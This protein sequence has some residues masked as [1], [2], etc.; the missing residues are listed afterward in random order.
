MKRNQTILALLLACT[1]CHTANKMTTSV[2]QVNETTVPFNTDSLIPG[3]PAYGATTVHYNRD[4]KQVMTVQLMEPQTL[5]VADKPEKWGHFQ[6]P[7]IDKMV[8]GNV[9]VRWSLSDDAMEAYGKHKYGQMKS[10]D[11][12]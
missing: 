9:R 6:F 3:I 8:D 5:S 1:A 2:K 11:G 10:P 4:G 7:H 12:R